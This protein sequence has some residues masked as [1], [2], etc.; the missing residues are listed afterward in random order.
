MGPRF[1]LFRIINDVPLWV[2][3][4]DTLEDATARAKEHCNSSECIVL[5]RLNGDTVIISGDKIAP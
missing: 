5:D 3:V 1:E 2:G 4:A